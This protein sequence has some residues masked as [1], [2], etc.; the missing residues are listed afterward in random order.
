MAPNREEFRDRDAT[1]ERYSEDYGCTFIG[2]IASVIVIVAVFAILYWSNLPYSIEIVGPP[3][4]NTDFEL[5]FVE[6]SLL[7]V[8]FGLAAVFIVW[9]Y[10]RR[11]RSALEAV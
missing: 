5:F 10:S 2:V 3:E 11:N 8:P 6:E 7:L 4:P 9:L 1:S